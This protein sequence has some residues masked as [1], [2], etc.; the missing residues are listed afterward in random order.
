MNKTKLWLQKYCRI[1][2]AV[3]A[4]FFIVCSSC[5]PVCAENETEDTWISISTSY[6]SVTSQKVRTI[7]IPFSDTLFNEKSDHYNHKLAQASLGLALAAFRPGE[8]D[9]NYMNPDSH[10]TDFLAQAGFTGIRTNDYDRPSGRYTIANAFGH[11]EIHDKEG[12]YELIAIGISGQGYQ[13]EWLSN[14]SIGNET[15]HVGF[16]D[17]AED[18][19]DRFFG[20]LAA[21]GLLNKRLKVWVTGFSRS[22][23]VANIFSA[24]LTDS[25][26]VEEENIFAYTFATPNTTKLPEP[27]K[28]KN[29]YNIVGATDLV[30]K[31]P[32]E[33]WGFSRYGTTK[34]LPSQETSSYWYIRAQKAKKIYKNVTGL[35][36]WNNPA[37]FQGLHNAM[38]YLY[39]I[40]PNTEIYTNIL[41]S[42]LLSLWKDHDP[43]NTLKI[44]FEISDDNE[45][46]TPENQE[47]A[48]RLLDFLCYMAFVVMNEGDEYNRWEKQT[49]AAVNIVHEHTPDIYVSWMF[50]TDN[51]DEL[52]TDN[53]NYHEIYISGD[54]DIDLCNRDGELIETAKT[55]EPIEK[56]SQTV[57]LFSVRNDAGE[58]Y[59]ILP[60][61]CDYE[62]K[63]T[64]NSDEGFT[65]TSIETGVENIQPADY[66]S[67]H[68]KAAIGD[69]FSV[70]VLH[71]DQE[72]AQYQEEGYVDISEFRD[73]LSEIGFGES[74]MNQSMF[75]F[76]DVNYFGLDWKTVV[77]LVFT[78]SVIFTALLLFLF[79]VAAGKLSV[80]AK[81]YSG[82]YPPKARYRVLPVFLITVAMVFAVLAILFQI[83][84]WDNIGFLTAMR[85]VSAAFIAVTAYLGWKRRPT[86]LHLMTLIGIVILGIGFAFLSLNESIRTL[87]FIAGFLCLICGMLSISKVRLMQWGLL[88]MLVVPGVVFTGK[89]YYLQDPVVLLA[90]LEYGT[91]A[92]V[93][94]VSLGTPRR[95]KIGSFLLF[96]SIALWAF[97]ILIVSDTLSNIA[98][99]AVI[100]LCF[101][102]ALSHY[103]IAANKVYISSIDSSPDGRVKY[104]WVATPDLKTTAKDKP[105]AEEKRE[106]EKKESETGTLTSDLVQTAETEKDTEQP[107]KKEAEAS[108]ITGQPESNVPEAEKKEPEENVSE[109]D[110]D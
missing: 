37:I 79:Q 26:L 64:Q 38:G 65:F 62:F 90:L 54:C 67:N 18:I 97:G 45:L 1:V 29:I 21:Q 66:S 104:H 41:Q 51:P 22:A 40:C 15:V 12:S 24:R 109:N 27:E 42:R 77:V 32:L 47:S 30:P 4:V 89:Y 25:A 95:F 74:D 49:S 80:L 82:A 86:R 106:T 58:Y 107:D 3:T 96:L 110:A 9:E 87:L 20:Y 75:S 101:C 8:Q 105:A 43:V 85:L 78:M 28:Y 23:A 108:V 73:E 56:I 31:V 35:E 55:D 5:L 50:S 71:E 60:M 34:V 98:T 16:S 13:S 68:I 69:I 99:S 70:L 14:L 7:D 6:P 10:V 2:F 63:I 36:F 93:L 88:A 61:D 11:K 94:V 52:F 83:P 103:A 91:A 84:Y 48:N 39:D 33:A 76:E 19:Y 17:A 53:R 92:A 81:I 100:H 72:E 46:I 44:L 59:A 102:A 57:Q